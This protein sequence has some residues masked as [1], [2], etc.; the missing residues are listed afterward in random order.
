MH[1]NYGVVFVIISP[2]L[3]Y[4]VAYNVTLHT[5]KA[6]EWTL[7]HFF[8]FGDRMH[9]FQS[10]HEWERTARG[11]LYL[12]NINHLSALMENKLQQ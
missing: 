8:L 1:H 4:C 7:N 12:K 5:Y 3:Q 10:H 9:V 2:I 11:S 6:T